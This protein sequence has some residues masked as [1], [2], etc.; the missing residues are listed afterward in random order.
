MPEQMD[1][2]GVDP[3]PA[4]P[5]GGARPTVTRMLFFAVFPDAEAAARLHAAA[6]R[7]R[8]SRGLTGRVLAPERL[9]VTLQPL[10]GDEWLAPPLLRAACEAGK[11]A[12][13]HAPAVPVAFDQAMSFGR[14]RMPPY[15]LAGEAGA[16][17]LRLLHR[18]LARHARNRGLPAGSAL[19]PHMTLLYDSQAVPRHDVEPVAWTARDLVLVLSHRGLTRHEVVGRWPL[20]AGTLQ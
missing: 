1:L 17:G 13:A 14:R 2:P 3:A 4:R 18:T 6:S 16:E 15:V 5:G 12:A 7:L 8:R 11:A 9:H 20:A 10:G 19:T